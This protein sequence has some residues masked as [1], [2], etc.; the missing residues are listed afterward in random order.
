MG[1]ISP[2]LKLGGGWLPDKGCGVGQ[3]VSLFWRNCADESV[4]GS[5][6]HELFSG[7]PPADRGGRVVIGGK[8]DDD[9]CVLRETPG[10]SRVLVNLEF[11]V[12]V[13]ENGSVRFVDEDEVPAQ[14]LVFVGR[15][16]DAVD[17]VVEVVRDVL[18]VPLLGEAGDVLGEDVVEGFE[19]AGSDRV[20]GERDG[21]RKLGIRIGGQE[22][23]DVGVVSDG[24]RHSSGWVHGDFETPQ[25]DDE[26]YVAVGERRAS[27]R[28]R[29]A[30]EI[31]RV[32][33]RG[34]PPL[35]PQRRPRQR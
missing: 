15:T 30:L 12:E 1:R 33:Q 2:G 7:N 32:G 29:H 22:G 8:L 34:I 6:R 23:V 14:I 20:P 26:V 19:I 13:A 28:D 35:S 25:F 16:G 24:S 11:V 21:N 9:G 17:L 27:S 18:A 5:Q 31:E 10:Q 3:G 4:A